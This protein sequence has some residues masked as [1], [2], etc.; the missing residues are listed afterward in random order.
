MSQ[1][2]LFII[3]ED[4][5]IHQKWK[6][7]FERSHEEILNDRIFIVSY[8]EVL[9]LDCTRII[10]MI[11]VLQHYPHLYNDMLYSIDLRFLKADGKT[12]FEVMEACM[13]ITILKY[14]EAFNN[15]FPALYFFWKQENYRFFTRLGVFGGMP[16]QVVAAIMSNGELGS[17]LD[18]NEVQSG[19]L[20]T[21]KLNA[22]RGL[23]LFF[24][25]SGIDPDPYILQIL[26]VDSLQIS[27]EEIK[28]Y[29]IADLMSH[30]LNLQG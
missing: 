17:R 20:F 2:R 27:L 22:C 29:L 3:K 19:L 15:Y 23:Q 4:S 1:N 16:A 26:N 7:Y 21:R 28:A 10:E 8:E 14:F 12:F 30:N 25:G 6:W 13:T 18:Y 5:E 9:N 24:Y 11:S